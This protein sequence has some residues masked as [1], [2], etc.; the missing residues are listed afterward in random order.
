MS[1]GKVEVTAFLA[2][3]RDIIQCDQ[4]MSSHL[5]LL[6]KWMECLP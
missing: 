3:M 6:D 5:L 4:I 1:T 2:I